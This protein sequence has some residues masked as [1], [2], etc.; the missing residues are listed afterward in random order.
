MEEQLQGLLD[1]IRREG[2]ERAETEAAGI[3]EAAEE[4]ARGIVADAQAQA[5]GLRAHAEA[6]AEASRERGSKALEQA[7]RDFLL[8]LQTDLHP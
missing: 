7:G 5:D 1:R 4:R 3:V 2:V 8:S 6:D